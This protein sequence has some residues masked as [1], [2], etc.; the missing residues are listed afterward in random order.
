M[1]APP[2]SARPVVTSRF[3]SW[4]LVVGIVATPIL[5]IFA[6]LI[7][8]TIYAASTI[9]EVAA[10]PVRGRL[11]HPRNPVLLALTA[12]TVWALLSSLWSATTL[13][14][15]A[16]TALAFG[17][18][19]VLGLWTTG[20]IQTLS[21][22]TL[23]RLRTA[24]LLGVGL[25]TLIVIIENYGG[26]PLT[27]AWAVAKHGSEPMGIELSNFISR[28]LTVLVMMM[29]PA[30]L[31][32]RRHNPWIA[33]LA[34][35]GAAYVL[36]HV[37]KHAVALAVISGFAG[38]ALSWAVPRMGMKALRA[39][40][41][42]L[43]LTVPLADH[44]LPQ[45]DQIASL[46]IFNSA[47][48]RLVIWRFAMDHYWEHPLRGWGIESSRAIPGGTGEAV[49]EFDDPN[50]VH[51]IIKYPLL[52]LHPHNGLIQLWLELG[53]PGALL[54]AAF[55]WVTLG[56]AIAPGDDRWTVAAKTAAVACGLTIAC[57]SFGI[58]QAWWISVLWLTANL[59]ALAPPP[60]LDPA[61]A[62]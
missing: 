15:A 46:N 40:V 38:F 11:L 27:R 10:S 37:G 20:L 18:T 53:V 60:R 56:R 36:S 23:A 54:M 13:G 3:T 12:L 45:M 8:A 2:L 16:R 4:P 17:I 49:L 25:G 62:P 52:P 19:G 50:H 57:I 34:L 55:L 14:L 6:G 58:W 9:F 35:A 51:V 33:A 41:V 29:W 61:V 47:R 32:L 30:Y 1:T 44:F 28:G 24:L 26:Y 42:A 22:V 48:H 43:V 31:V 5:S 39:A 7:P 21:P 59:F